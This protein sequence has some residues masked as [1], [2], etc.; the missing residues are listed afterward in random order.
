MSFPPRGILSLW[1]RKQSKPCLSEVASDRVCYD[2]NRQVMNANTGTEGWC[3]FC[4]DNLDCV[5]LEE[6]FAS[7][8]NFELEKLLSAYSL[9]SYCCGGSLEDNAKRN[10]DN[11]APACVISE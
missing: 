10:E 8:W 11:G 3:R 7:I 9:I 5:V 2:S 1:N 6:D 4:D